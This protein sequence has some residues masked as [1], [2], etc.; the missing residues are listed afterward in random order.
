MR[1]HATSAAVSAHASGH[2]GTGFLLTLERTVGATSGADTDLVT[3]GAFGAQVFP[4]LPAA[5]T[6]ANLWK[7]MGSS[8]AT[9][10]DED[11]GSDVAPDSLKVITVAANLRSMQEIEQ[12]MVAATTAGPSGRPAD[13]LLLVTGS[14]PLRT[15]PGSRRLLPTSLATL[16][17]ASQLKARGVIPAATQ[18]WAVANPNNEQ[19]AGLAAEKVARGASVLLTQPPLDAGAFEAWLRDADR[20]GLG[21]QAR[22]VV[23]HPWFTSASNA[24][25]WGALAGCVRNRALA[26]LVTRLSAAEAGGKGSVDALCAELNAGLAKKALGE[27]SGV[28]GGM[29]V[30][31]LSGKARKGVVAALQ[32]GGA[33]HEARLAGGR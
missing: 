10:Q 19:G 12:R 8:A 29:H 24:A 23:G 32:P 13:A 26:T 30:M 27:W 28:V 18:L 15:L 16:E 5:T 9:S 6:W 2:A 17:L 4:D 14:H 31:P 33:L 7:S 1:M 3:T 11:K 25:F 20:R 21:R 22:L